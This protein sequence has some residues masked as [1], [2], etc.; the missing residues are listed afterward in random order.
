MYKGP[1]S[2]AWQ[3]LLFESMAPKLPPQR[4]SPNPDPSSGDW[5]PGSGVRERRATVAG[6]HLSNTTRLTHV[7]FESGGLCSRLRWSL[8]RRS[9]HKTGE[10]ALEESRYASSA[11]QHNWLKCFTLVNIIDAMWQ[12]RR[13]GRPLPFGRR[14]VRETYRDTANLHEDPHTVRNKYYYYYYY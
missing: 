3:R 13:V 12:I 9:T 8:T 6:S 14:S 11:T 7:F 2:A 1:Y 4:V 10:A 5:D